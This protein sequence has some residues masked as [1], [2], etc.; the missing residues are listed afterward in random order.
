M[1]VSPWTGLPA[2]VFPCLVRSVPRVG[3]RLATL[4]GMEP[5]LKMK[6]SMEAS[7]L[8]SYTGW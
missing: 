4:I 2:E 7:C 1:G 8:V 6:E 5:L 3:S